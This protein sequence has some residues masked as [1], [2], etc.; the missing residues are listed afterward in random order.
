LIFQD[1]KQAM[2]VFERRVAA[3]GCGAARRLADT[4][5]AALEQSAPL[6]IRA[7]LDELTQPR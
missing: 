5:F 2:A 1:R 4:V 3:A 6:G 7:V